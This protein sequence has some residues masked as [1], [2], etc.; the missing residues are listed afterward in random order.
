MTELFIRSPGDNDWESCS[1]TEIVWLDRR[2]LSGGRDRTL[3]R[4][5]RCPGLRRVSRDWELFSRDTTHQVYVAP[6]AQGQPPRYQAVR[7]AAQ[8]VLPVASARFEPVPVPLASGTWAVS[9]GAWVLLLRVESSSDVSVPPLPDDQLETDYNRIVADHPAGQ[10]GT[11]P[12]PDAPA[13]VRAF[14]AHNES[15]R[16][17]MAYYY[18]EFILGTAAPQEVPM[19]IVAAALNLTGQGAVSDYKRKLQDCIWNEQGH[20]RELAG[21]LLTNSLINLA[22]LEEARRAA[23]AN[24]LNGQVDEARRRLRYRPRKPGPV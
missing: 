7:T 22:D 2:L 16:M 23:L 13:R 19:P 11:A 10:A 20:Q 21:F 18:Q 9:I 1:P 12:L 17:A 24:E 5:P 8:H 15:A 6:Y 14:F 4:A 3:H